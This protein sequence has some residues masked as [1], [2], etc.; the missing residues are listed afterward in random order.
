MF[1]T[2]ACC[3][4]LHLLNARPRQIWD[5]VPVAAE[6]QGRDPARL[7]PLKP[8]PPNIVIRTA[9]RRAEEPF[10]GFFERVNPG[11]FGPDMKAVV[12]ARPPSARPL[13]LLLPTSFSFGHNL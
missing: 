13:L 11:D 10:E 3:P 9:Y 5:W 4:T 12:K 8:L 2:I 7:S 6:R 1:R